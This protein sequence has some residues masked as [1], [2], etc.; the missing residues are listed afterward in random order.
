[1]T[2]PVIDDLVGQLKPAK[3]LSVAA[4]WLGAG[5]GFVAAAVYVVSLYGIR[6][7][8]LS[9]YVPLMA[10]IKPLIFLVIS[11]A[12]L[13]AVAAL[14]RPQGRMTGGHVAFVLLMPVL[15]LGITA[16]EVAVAG[17]GS[18]GEGLKGGT[19]LCFT[20]ILC[21]GMAGLVA[22]WRLWLRQTATS[23]PR[24]LGAMAGL[25]VAS[26][27]ATAYALHCNMD[28]PIYILLVYG[29]PVAAISLLAAVAGGKLLRW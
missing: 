3:R 9:G 18:V 24:L 27:M 21:G 2:D 25:A 14:A 26:L 8:V 10:I 5:M 19:Q 13:S 12:A 23:Q 15:V 7:G 28:A 20:T 4:L 11:V 29:L 16:L 22:L 1:M 6:P 17:W